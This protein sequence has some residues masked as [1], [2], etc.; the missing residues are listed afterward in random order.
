[1]KPY[2]EK[3]S[4]NFDDDARMY[5]VSYTFA[6]AFHPSLNLDGPSVVKSFNHTFEQLNS[7]NNLSDEMLPYFDPITILQLRDCAQA[8]HEKKKKKK[9]SI[10]EIFS[11]DLKFVIDLPKEMAWQ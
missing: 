10:S 11:C 1:M 4:Y 8:V 3:N 5:L 9:K 7:M 2:A 6:V